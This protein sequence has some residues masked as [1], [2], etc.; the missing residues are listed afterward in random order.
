MGKNGTEYE[1]WHKGSISVHLTKKQ[2]VKVLL[3]SN[4]YVGGVGIVTPLATHIHSRKNTWLMGFIS[5]NQRQVKIHFYSYRV[6]VCVCVHNNP[7]NVPSFLF[8]NLYL[9]SRRQ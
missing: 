5:L 7:I 3:Q 8:N 1:I 2:K 4:P 6:C 9:E